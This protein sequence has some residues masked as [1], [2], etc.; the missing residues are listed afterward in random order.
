MSE[1]YKVVLQRIRDYRTSFM[2]A[3]SRF[4]QRVFGRIVPTKN[5]IRK[6]FMADLRML[7]EEA[8]FMQDKKVLN[9]IQGV[10]KSPEQEIK[11][12]VNAINSLKVGGE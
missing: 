2:N 10:V 4:G 5:D 12:Q 6:D 8:V 3:P 9:L 7:G 11:E 1:L